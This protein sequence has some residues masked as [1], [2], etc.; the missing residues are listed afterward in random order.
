M[1]CKKEKNS[2][3]T[4]TL[5]SSFTTSNYYL[6]YK[7]GIMKKQTTEGQLAPQQKAKAVN[8]TPVMLRL[9]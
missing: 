7:V 5:E 8:H 3:S 9:G 1:L 6:M 2:K 4:V